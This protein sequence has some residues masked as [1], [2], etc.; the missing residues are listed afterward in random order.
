MLELKDRLS[1]PCDAEE[2]VHILIAMDNEFM[3]M[4]KP[5]A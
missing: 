2:C 5:G 3:A 4:H 1:W